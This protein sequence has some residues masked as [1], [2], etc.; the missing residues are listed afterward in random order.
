MGDEGDDP[1]KPIPY[2]YRH[3]FFGECQAYRKSKRVGKDNIEIVLTDQ[4]SEKN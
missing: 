1:I 2:A 3:R 4:L